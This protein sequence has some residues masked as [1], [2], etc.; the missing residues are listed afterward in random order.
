MKS[1]NLCNTGKKT[2][3]YNEDSKNTAFE[4]HEHLR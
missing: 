4:A 2:S 1:K 3:Y